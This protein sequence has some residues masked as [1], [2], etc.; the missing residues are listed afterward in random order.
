MVLIGRKLRI[1]NQFRN[2]GNKRGIITLLSG[3][4]KKCLFCFCFVFFLFNGRSTF[5]D[6]LIQTLLCR[7]IVI[8]FL[9]LISGNKGYHFFLKIISPKVNVKSWLKFKLPFVITSS[10]PT[11]DKK[12]FAK[13]FTVPLFNKKDTTVG[14]ISQNYLHAL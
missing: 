1:I 4:K 5:M 3:I 10:F 12:Y 2:Q 9:P 14:F 13:H 7:R 8:T 6:R 11:F